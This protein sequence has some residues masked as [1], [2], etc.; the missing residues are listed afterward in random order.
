MPNF[1]LCNFLACVW[2]IAG[3]GFWDN[4]RGP[5]SYGVPISLDPLQATD[6]HELGPLPPFEPAPPLPARTLSPPHPSCTS[7]GRGKGKG[8][9][10]ERGPGSWLSRTVGGLGGGI[11]QTGTPLEP[12]HL[13]SPEFFCPIEERIVLKTSP[14]YLKNAWGSFGMFFLIGI[15]FFCRQVFGR[16]AHR[17]QFHLPLRSPWPAKGIQKFKT[18]SPETPR[19]KIK[20]QTISVRQFLHQ[21]YQT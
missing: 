4:A 3:L 9:R 1:Y 20:T 21:N 5:S 10:L 8:S 15:V 2:P 13:A 16:K 12:G 7:L 18:P 17:V 6:R 11:P 19:N 14:T